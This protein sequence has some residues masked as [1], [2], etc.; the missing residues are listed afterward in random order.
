MKDF[1]G[2]ELQVGDTV[3]FPQPKYRNLRRGTVTKITP[4]KI[5]L[6]YKNHYGSIMTH[7]AESS[8]VIRLDIYRNGVGVGLIQDEPHT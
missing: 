4:C 6:E 7:T 8:D 5:K 3:A 1:I 2:K